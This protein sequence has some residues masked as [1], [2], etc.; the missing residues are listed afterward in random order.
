MVIRKL[1]R[2]FT[3]VELLVVIA[4][5]GVLVGL[6]LPAVQ[7]ARDS[8]RRMQCSNNLKQVGL[9]VLNYESS[10]KKFPAG[11]RAKTDAN[12]DGPYWSTWTIDVLPYME[13][14]GLHARWNPTV[15]LEDVKNRDI[16]QQRVD[17]YLCPSD[18]DTTTLVVPETGPGAN[19]AA[20]NNQYYP[21]SYRANSGSGTDSHCGSYWD[22]PLGMAWL[23]LDPQV[24]LG[25]R[26]PMYAVLEKITQSPQASPPKEA[27]LAQI[28]DGTSSTRLAGEYMTLTNPRRRTLWAYAY[29]SYNQSSGIPDSRTLIPDYQQCNTL[30][31]D[32][33]CLEHCKRGWGS[34]HSGGVF[35]NVF[36]DGSVR[37]ISDAVDVDVFVAA[38]T[39]AGEE[40]RESL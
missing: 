33:T 26:G 27:T 37:P 20:P 28:T 16:K 5:I 6:L 12:Q 25:S 11:S 17:A 21:G 34:F 1:R 31:G 13:Q 39:I 4:I 9:A 36:C 7:A 23:V 29:T 30:P 8:A 40:N 22:N 38:C 24:G 18:I 2:G 15:H 35:Q 14:A 10:K 3:L 32:A 19:L